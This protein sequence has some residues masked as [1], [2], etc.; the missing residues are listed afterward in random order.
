V[1]SRSETGLGRTKAK[2]GIAHDV[3]IH[4]LSSKVTMGDVICEPQ[5][6]MRSAADIE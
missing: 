1:T 3:G 6:N 2:Y 5:K 4:L